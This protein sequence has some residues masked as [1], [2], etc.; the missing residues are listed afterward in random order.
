LLKRLPGAGF[1]VPLLRPENKLGFGCVESAGF[2]APKSPAA[3]CWPIVADPKSGLAWPF[4]AGGGPAG[5][6]ELVG[7]VN[8][9]AAG[10]VD[11]AGAEVAGAEELNILLLDVLF[12]L[13]NSPPACVVAGLS[14]LA[15][16][17]A[18][19]SPFFAPKLNPPPKLPALL[20][21][22]NSPP[23]V[24]AEVVV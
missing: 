21:V 24:P 23:D 4:A 18:P 19:P 16:V 6:V 14:L 20:V 12:R 10:V 15:G 1:V 8:L 17:D 2:A 9:F 13:G 5:V 11:P 22:P 3:G 7:N